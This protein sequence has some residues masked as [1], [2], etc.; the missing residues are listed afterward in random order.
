MQGLSLPADWLLTLT[1]VPSPALRRHCV[2]IMLTDHLLITGESDRAWSTE[3]PGARTEALEVEVG[4]GWGMGVANG[5][6]GPRL[7][8]PCEPQQ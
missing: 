8:K 5:V 3:L 7:C 2:G 4:I 1:V 6:T